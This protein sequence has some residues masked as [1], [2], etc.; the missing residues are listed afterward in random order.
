[1]KFHPVQDFSAFSS[2]APDAERQ[3]V[4]QYLNVHCW[5]KTFLVKMYLNWAAKI[6]TENL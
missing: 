4:E 2:T 5:K 6:N 1:M 3:N